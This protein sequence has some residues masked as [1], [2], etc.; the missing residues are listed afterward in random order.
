MLSK[1]I[2]LVM[3]ICFGKGPLSD[4]EEPPAAPPTIKIGMSNLFKHP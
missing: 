4:M 1:N 3:S 2:A